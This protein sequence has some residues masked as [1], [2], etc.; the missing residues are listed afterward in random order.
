VAHTIRVGLDRFVLDPL[1]SEALEE[2]LET[3]DGEG[4]PPG[5]RAPRSAR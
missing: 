5:A 4:D 2:R 1:G 3:S